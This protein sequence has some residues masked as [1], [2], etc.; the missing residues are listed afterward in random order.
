M[1]SMS[2]LTSKLLMSILMCPFFVV[3]LLVDDAEVV[4][5]ILD[6]VVLLD[7]LCFDEPFFVVVFLLDEVDV[8]IGR[9]VFDIPTALDV[10]GVVG[11]VL[12]ILFYDVL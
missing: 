4:V 12:C 3:V 8:V 2:M 7:V 6:V 10:Q 11:D 5:T 1:S 9:D